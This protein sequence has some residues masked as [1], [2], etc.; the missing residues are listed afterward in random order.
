MV[1]TERIAVYLIFVLIL[2]V[3]MIT[4]M[5]SLIIFILQKKE[6]MQILVV[7]GLSHQ[8]LKKIFMIWGQI[9]V[10]IG[11]IIGLIFGYSICILQSNLQFLKIKGN[12]IIDYYPI[13]INLLDGII[14]ISIVYTLGFI[15]SYFIS[16]KNHFYK[17]LIYD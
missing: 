4:L 17:D 15:T 2:L 12:F 13:E 6:D 10:V 3:T 11:L 14:I 1:N 9:I 8:S 5:G 7:L 16:K